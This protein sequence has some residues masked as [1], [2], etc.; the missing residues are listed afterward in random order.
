MSKSNRSYKQFAKGLVGT[1]LT[2]SGIEVE[3]DVQ[4]PGSTEVVDIVFEPR[5]R[6][7]GLPP[8]AMHD[9]LARKTIERERK[10]GFTDVFTKAFAEAFAECFA[11]A[12]EE[13]RKDAIAESLL[14]VLEWRFGELPEAVTARVARS[15]KE[16]LDRW[17]QRALDAA[18]L[19]D[20]FAR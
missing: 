9:R 20:V 8:R 15:S 17:F 19:D 6:V 13:G 2:G 3:L 10:E 7:S 16:T 5:P 14:Q 18:T 12:F 1:V 4:V 11:E